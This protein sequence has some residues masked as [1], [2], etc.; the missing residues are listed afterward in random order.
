[1]LVGARLDAA[2]RAL[3]AGEPDPGFV[4][5]AAAGVDDPG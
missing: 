5:F 4:T 3:L 1:V 2:A